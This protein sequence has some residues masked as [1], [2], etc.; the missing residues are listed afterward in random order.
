MPIP[1]KWFLQFRLSETNIF[2]SEFLI[3]FVRVALPKYLL[4][5]DIITLLRPGE[6]RELCSSYSLP[7]A[8]LISAIV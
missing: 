4:L 1:T 6:E 3:L 2:F 7:S 5:P 8:Y